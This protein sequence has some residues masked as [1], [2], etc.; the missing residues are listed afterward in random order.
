MKK[1]IHTSEYAAVLRLLRADREASGV[2]QVELAERLGTTQS[3]VSKIER[4]EARLD[5][6]QLRTVCH[7]IGVTVVDFVKRL[8][9]ELKGAK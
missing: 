7:A 1:S 5:V 8:E 3:H 6:I 4:G 9:G 2:T